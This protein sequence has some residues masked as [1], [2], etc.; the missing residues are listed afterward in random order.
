VLRQRLGSIAEGSYVDR[1]N[2]TLGEF[3]Q[4]WLRTYVITNT[5]PS[6]QRGYEANVRRNIAPALGSIPLQ[7]LRPQDIQR[8]YANMLERG[9]SARTVLHT[10]RVLREAL[11]HAV[12]WSSLLPTLPMQRRRPALRRK[13]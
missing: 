10:H 11:S 12:K 5:T 8:L 4:R 7:K 2:E 9:L 3:M 13:S 6:T 1:S